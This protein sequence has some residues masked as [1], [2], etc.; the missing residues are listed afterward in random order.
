M[1]EYSNNILILEYS[2][3]TLIL[4]Y[5]NNTLILEYSKR[6]CGFGGFWWVKKRIKSHLGRSLGIILTYTNAC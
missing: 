3:N 2:N 5:S 1:L 6:V 4:E